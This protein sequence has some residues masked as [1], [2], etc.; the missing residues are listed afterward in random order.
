MKP[1]LIKGYNGGDITFPDDPSL[2]LSPHEFP[3][4]AEK[5]GNDIITASGTTLLGADDKAG[6]A[7][8]M[9]A[10]RHLLA[11]RDRVHGPIRIAFTP[12]EEIG[13]GV[14][15]QLPKDLRADFAYTFDGGKL[16]EIEYEETT[17]E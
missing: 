4:L 16:G 9:T 7:I 1:R 6:V 17:R 3:Y 10:A 13:R 14:G 2:V 5:Q 11:N 12:D 15:D 8:I